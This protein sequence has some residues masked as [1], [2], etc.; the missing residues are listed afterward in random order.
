MPSVFQRISAS[1]TLRPS[2]RSGCGMRSYI[3][4]RARLL[5]TSSSPD[6]APLRHQTPPAIRQVRRHAIA[7]RTD[8]EAGRLV[9]AR[10]LARPHRRHSPPCPPRAAAPR[11]TPATPAATIGDGPTVRHEH[12]PRAIPRPPMS[13]PGARS[14]GGAVHGVRDEGCWTLCPLHAGVRQTPPDETA[15]VGSPP[16]SNVPGR[17]DRTASVPEFFLLQLVIHPGTFPVSPRGALSGPLAAIRPIRGTVGT[18]PGY[19]E[20]CEVQR[21]Q[22]RIDV[23]RP[24]LSPHPPGTTASASPGGLRPISISPGMGAR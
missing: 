11:T 14:K 16:T 10:R 3:C 23:A 17:N 19:F 6:T 1:G 2:W 15:R 12:M 7:A 18:L 24:V 20:G 4:G 22:R 13:C 21:A 5:V 9:H 8:G